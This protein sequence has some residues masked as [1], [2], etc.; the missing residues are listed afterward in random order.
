MF[1]FEQQECH[2]R[3]NAEKQARVPSATSSLPHMSDL[4]RW[5]G[6]D[7]RRALPQVVVTP[8]QAGV[9]E[10]QT[11]RI[12]NPVLAR[13]CGFNSHLRYF[14]QRFTAPEAEAGSAS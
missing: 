12:Q 13:V 3:K 9:A 6:V 14:F 7:N 1:V 2:E 8:K 11:R 10:W 5:Q 4:N